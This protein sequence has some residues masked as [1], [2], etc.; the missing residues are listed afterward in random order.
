MRLDHGLIESAKEH[1]RRTDRSL[2]QLVADYFALLASAGGAR[3][4]APGTPEDEA[5]PPA[6]A[7]LHGSLCGSTLDERDYGEHLAEKHA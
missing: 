5:L 7:A 6:V 2:S 4:Q 3:A 1:A